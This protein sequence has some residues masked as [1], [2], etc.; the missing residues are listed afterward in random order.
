M[1]DERLVGIVKGAGEGSLFEV[2]ETAN[3]LQLL[4]SQPT[5]P[6]P[7]PFRFLTIS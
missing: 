5:H 1:L 3:L 7:R 2:R 6:P 4:P